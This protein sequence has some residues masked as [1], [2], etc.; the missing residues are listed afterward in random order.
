VDG[1]GAELEGLSADMELLEGEL[2]ALA[3]ELDGR[4]ID[5]ELARLL[6]ALEAR[7]RALALRRDQLQALTLHAIQP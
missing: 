2:Q 5:P 4:A 1:L 6:A 3:G 7:T